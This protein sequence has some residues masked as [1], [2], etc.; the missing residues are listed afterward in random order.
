MRRTDEEHAAFFVDPHRL[1][2]PRSNLGPQL[3]GVAWAS[4]DVSDGLVADPRHICE[5]SKPGAIIEASRV[6][7]SDAART[8]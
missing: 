7:L 5:V 4:V 1:P 8:P 6:R 2:R 3:I